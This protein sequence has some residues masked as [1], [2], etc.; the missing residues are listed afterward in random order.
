MNEIVEIYTRFI[1]DELLESLEWEK[2]SPG[3][4]VGFTVTDVVHN[5]VPLGQ[6]T[7]FVGHY[8]DDPQTP[9]FFEISSDDITDGYVCYRRSLP[10]NEAQLRIWKQLS[11][12]NQS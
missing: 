9:T 4:L 5:N 7:L 12:S 6:L 1:P 2:I 8:S 11:E 10:L 3:A